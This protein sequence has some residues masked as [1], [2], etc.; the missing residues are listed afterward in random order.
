MAVL[1]LKRGYVLPVSLNKAQRGSDK[2]NM[3]TFL[4]NNSALKMYRLQDGDN[5]LHS[6]G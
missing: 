4:Q 2:T 1:I 6:R 5:D 3:S